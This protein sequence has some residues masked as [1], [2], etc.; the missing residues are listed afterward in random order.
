MRKQSLNLIRQ[1]IPYDMASFYLGKK[2]NNTI[3]LYNAVSIDTDIK[4]L[5]SYEDY[6]GEIDFCKVVFSQTN[7]NTYRDT[8]LI[9]CNKRKRTEIL[10]DYM[11]PKGVYFSAGD[12]IICNKQFLGTLTLF[13]SK[14]SG[15]FTSKE[16][17]ILKLMNTHLEKR[18]INEQNNLKYWQNIINEFNFTKREMEIINLLSNGL[19]N[20]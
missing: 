4:F 1:I 18:L 14:K 3:C 11:I 16:L 13:R 2:N 12:S 17:F 15:D 5:K 7:S 20:K 10:N 9:D 19:T 8:D 6:N